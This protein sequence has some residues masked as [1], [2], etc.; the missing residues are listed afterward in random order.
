M[1]KVNRRAG[2]IN[3]S[4]RPITPGEV[5]DSGRQLQKEQRTDKLSFPP[6][7]LSPSPSLPS[8]SS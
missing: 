2:E 8:S 7:S 6:P 1:L 4:Q 5:R 3:K